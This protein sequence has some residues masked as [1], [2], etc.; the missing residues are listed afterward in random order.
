MPTFSGENTY[1]ITSHT[2]KTAHRI[3]SKA[4][5]ISPVC[6]YTLRDTTRPLWRVFYLESLTCV[7]VCVCVYTCAQ[8]CTCAPRQ[9]RACAQACVYIRARDRLHIIHRLHIILFL[10]NSPT[11]HQF[12]KSNSIQFRRKKRGSRPLNSPHPSA[13]KRL[14]CPV[15]S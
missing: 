6:V 13:P 8:A 9:A 11:A 12:N 4:C 3:A 7:C 15:A 5:E 2:P 1:H 14:A 10:L